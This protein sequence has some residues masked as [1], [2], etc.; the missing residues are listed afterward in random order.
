[1]TKKVLLVLGASSDIGT[2]LIK[3]S[4]K[5]YDIIVAH[6]N[7]SKT[8]LHN[9]KEEIGDKLKLIQANFKKETNI[10]IFVKE[11]YKYCD[12]PNHIVNLPASKV[13]NNKFNEIDWEEFKLDFNIQL[14][15]IFKVLKEFLPFMA[16]D[17]YGKVVF[18]LT[19]SVTNIPPKYLCQYVTIKYALLGLMKSLSAEYSNKFININAISPHMIETKFLEDLSHLSVEMSAKNSPMKRNARV[20]DIIPMIEFLLSNKADYIMGQNIVIN[21]GNIL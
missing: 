19:S 10:D 4:F 1:M 14:G 21:G 12:F 15:A 18:L 11:I 13:K 8:L 3:E 16:K 6:Y 17:R 5:R 2:Q 7:T 20:D 9:L